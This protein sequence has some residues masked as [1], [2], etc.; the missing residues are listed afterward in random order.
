MSGNL[1]EQSRAEVWLF[2]CGLVV[3]GQ[4]DTL[5]ANCAGGLRLLDWKRCRNVRFDSFGKSL[6]PP[7]E[8]LEDCNGWLYSPGSNGPGSRTRVFLTNT[9]DPLKSAEY[10]VQLNTYP[11]WRDMRGRQPC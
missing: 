9:P 2:H 11:G 10:A 4:L 6:A 5:F 3:A 8:H 1:A 7:L